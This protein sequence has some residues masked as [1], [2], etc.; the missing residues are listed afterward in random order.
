MFLF[1]GRPRTNRTQVMGL[2]T[3][4]NILYDLRLVMEGVALFI[5]I[6]FLGQRPP[7]R[8]NHTQVGLRTMFLIFMGIPRTNHTLVGLRLWADHEQNTLMCGIAATGSNILYDLRL[9]EAFPHGT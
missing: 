2:R 3:G 7:P 9:N 6:G 8:A 4:S 5:I 1:M